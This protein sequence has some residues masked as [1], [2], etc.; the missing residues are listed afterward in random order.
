M[1][2]NPKGLQ[3]FI[4]C[5]FMPKSLDHLDVLSVYVLRSKISNQNNRGTDYTDALWEESDRVCKMIEGSWTGGR[6]I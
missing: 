4:Q 3:N 2:I 5:L 6:K 1:F